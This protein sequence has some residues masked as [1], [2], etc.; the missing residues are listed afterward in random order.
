M[1][2]YAFIAIFVTDEFPDGTLPYLETKLC[3]DVSLTTEVMAIFVIFLAILA[4]SWLPWQ[5]PL[6]PCNQK[7]LIWIGRPLKLYL[8]P[9]IL[10]IAD[11]Q[12]KLCRFEAS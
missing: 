11:T 12:A 10:S 6:D 8:E 5:R 9:K 1:H 4:K 3:I 7:C 2:L